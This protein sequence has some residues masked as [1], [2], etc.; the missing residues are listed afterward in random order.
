MTTST[1][2]INR[3][4]RVAEI[5]LD[6][7]D[8]LNAMNLE[9]VRD[10]AATVGGLVGEPD[11][12]A[13]V[14]RGAGRAFCSGLDLDMMGE[15]GMPPDFFAT[16]ER[17][18]TTLER[19]PAIVIAQI[20]GYCLGGGLQMALACDIRIAREDAMLGLPAALEGLPPGIAAW[21]LPRFVGIGRALRL[22]LLGKPVSAAEA[23]E[24]GL[25]DH[26]LPTEGFDE[27]A[28]DL[29][30]QYASVPHHA[31]VGI[32]EMV[33][34]SFDLGFDQAYDR[35]REI[36]ADC[37]QSPDVAAAKLAWAARRSG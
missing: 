14:I 5:F 21:R 28:R 25:V 11:L 16:Q 31:A 33:R 32:K 3:T 1:M 26:V 30:E 9:W 4:G 6:R 8:K 22:S 37:L 27:Q 18:F 7:P 15:Q 36:I 23:L 2:S 12:H 24:L 19:L 13:V 10:L 17:A 35:A 34:T 20:H 29:V